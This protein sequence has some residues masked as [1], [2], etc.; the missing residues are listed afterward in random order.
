MKTIMYLLNF[1]PALSVFTF[2]RADVANRP[3]YAEED[4]VF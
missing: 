2:Q 1:I 3:D 4:I